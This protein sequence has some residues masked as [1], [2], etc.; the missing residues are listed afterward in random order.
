MYLT[1]C[2]RIAHSP[3]FS[4]RFTT[5]YG[6]GVGQWMGGSFDHALDRHVEFH[7]DQPFVFGETLLV[8]SG[9]IYSIN[10]HDG[11]TLMQGYLVHWQ[12]I[13]MLEIGDNNIMI[14]T[15]DPH[16]ADQWVRLLVLPPNLKIYPFTI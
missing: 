14:D 3:G 10:V 6:P 11:W 7:V 9:R 5:A 2:E 1:G 12:E 16:Y 8:S 13:C 15:I 4:V